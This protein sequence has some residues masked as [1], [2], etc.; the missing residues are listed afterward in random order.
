[1]FKSVIGKG[2]PEFATSRQQDVV[3]YL[4]Y[5]LNAIEK[6][7][8]KYDNGQHD[9]SNVVK[10]E[11]EERTQ[12]M[13]SGKVKYTSIVDNL[14]SLPIPIKRAANYKEFLEYEERQKKI[15]EE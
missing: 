9:V 11:V 2:H 7:E 12:C 1:M 13:H 6:D 14:L 8:R 3:E 4:Q 5:L 10:F 15:K